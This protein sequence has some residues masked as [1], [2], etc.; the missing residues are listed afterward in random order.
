M[1]AASERSAPMAG[2]SSGTTTTTDST[3]KIESG[4]VVK[5]IGGADVVKISASDFTKAGV[6]DQKQVE[7]SAKNKFTVPAADL[8]KDALAYLDSDDDRFVVTDADV[9]A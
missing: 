4:K 7:W 5:Y 9:D 6:A 2:S 8:N 1:M 3:P